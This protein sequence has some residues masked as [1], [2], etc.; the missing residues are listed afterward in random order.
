MNK[1]N[2]LKRI[3][4]EHHQATNAGFVSY[5]KIFRFYDSY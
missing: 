5:P 4:V 2:I 3:F 1:S